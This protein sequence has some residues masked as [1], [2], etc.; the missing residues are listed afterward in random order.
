[1][2]IQVSKSWFVDYKRQILYI[3]L[4]TMEVQNYAWLYP[5]HPVKGFN[6][7]LE[8]GLKVVCTNVGTVHRSEVPN[9][10]KIPGSVHL[11]I[12][13]NIPNIFHFGP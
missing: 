2:E 5:M 6:I 9:I 10:A 4:T 13:H 3:D 11:Q 1:M 7:Q 12:A 8:W